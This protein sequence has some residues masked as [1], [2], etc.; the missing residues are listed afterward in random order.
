M[1]PITEGA[2]NL[3]ESF[4]ANSGKAGES[5]DTFISW[6]EYCL[7]HSS[8]G[9]AGSYGINTTVGTVK[10]KVAG[11][12]IISWAGSASYGSG[13]I[14]VLDAE[15]NVI[16]DDISS[17]AVS[18]EKKYGS[19]FIYK[20]EATTLTLKAVAGTV[21]FTEFTIKPWTNEE[22]GIE[23]VSIAGGNEVSVGQGL[24]LSSK[25]VTNY[26]FESTGVTW[27]S[28][29]ETIATVDANG[30]VTGVAAGTATITC[31]SLDDATKVATKEVTVI[32][33]QYKV[34]S[35]DFT[36]DKMASVN[37]QT[38]AETVT[39]VY[40]YEGN[41]VSTLA[42]SVSYVGTDGGKCKLSS[43]G[44]Y[45]QYNKDTQITIPVLKGDV[46]TVVSYPGQSKYTIT[47]GSDVVEADT[48]T[49]TDTITAAADGE[50]VILA[51]G[52]AY[53]YSIT[54]ESTK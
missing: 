13:I 45:A 1:N 32:A 43:N 17:Q 3:F 49:D 25:V 41:D 54:L 6:D 7:Y 12:S 20:G 48:D 47:C 8:N 5:P 10:I 18:G 31:T 28:S 21:Y 29:D 2:I 35:W 38:A 23:S 42:M 36:T 39:E 44:Q 4:S 16:Y 27:S 40:G 46:V 24:A 15:G 22:P 30:N 26:Y 19:G 33:T 34:V 50:V 14:D 51:T 9:D 52:G 37:I 53:I 11:D